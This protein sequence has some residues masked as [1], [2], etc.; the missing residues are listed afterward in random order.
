MDVKQTGNVA[1]LISSAKG[2]GPTKFEALQRRSVSNRSQ[3]KI[4]MV[5][6][7][8]VKDGF[9]RA[10]PISQKQRKKAMR[11]KTAMTAF[12]RGPGNWG[13]ARADAIWLRVCENRME[14]RKRGAKNPTAPPRKHI[15]ARSVRRG[16]RLSDGTKVK[17]RAP[18][19]VVNA[20]NLWAHTE[21]GDL[22]C[23]GV[24]A[25]KVA[26]WDSV[27][28]V[29]DRLGLIGALGEVAK[30]DGLW[31]AIAIEAVGE[32]FKTRKLAVARLLQIAQGV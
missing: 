14:N 29:E 31:H 23:R 28:L 19:K 10:R 6:P 21:Y 9:M 30:A 4:E 25:E 16:S 32:T 24:A 1:D 17:H 7:E 26:A 11:Q 3:S 5:I 12:N 22:I 15:R 27:Y 13:W 18:T 20:V 8:F 2:M